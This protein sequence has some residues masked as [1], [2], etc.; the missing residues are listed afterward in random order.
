[1]NPRRP[2]PR[3]EGAVPVERGVV[4]G[5]QKPVEKSAPAPQED[6]PSQGAQARPRATEQPPK[7]APVDPPV[8]HRE[9]PSPRV[10]NRW[11]QELETTGRYYATQIQRV[12]E[13]REAWE[14]K[15]AWMRA[16]NMPEWMIEGVAKSLG[17]PVPGQDQGQDS[18]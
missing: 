1:M 18:E 8:R 7:P 3:V 14:D 5:A 9:V 4:P 2:L 15:V 6:H 16:R 12:A 13:A 17:L 10:M 11:R